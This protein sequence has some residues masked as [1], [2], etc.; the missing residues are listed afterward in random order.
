M[1]L[2][3]KVANNAGIVYRL[4]SL[5]VFSKSCFVTVTV[6]IKLQVS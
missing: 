2:H 3:G 5:V 6:V 1:R 4:T